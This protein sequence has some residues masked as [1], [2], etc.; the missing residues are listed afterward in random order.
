MSVYDFGH[1]ESPIAQWLERSNRYSG[2]SFVGLP[3]KNSENLFPSISLEMTSTL[4][5]TLSK[6]Q[7][8]FSSMYAFFPISRG[9]CEI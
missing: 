4:I 8:H 6:S 1:H 9:N 7:F 2:R 5:F 3:L